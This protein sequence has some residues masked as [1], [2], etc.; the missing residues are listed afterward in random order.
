MPAARASTS[1]VPGSSWDAAVR[2]LREQPGQEDLVRAA[3]YDDPL[4]GAAQRYWESEEWQA[5][6]AAIGPRRGRAL[7]VG[8]G[9]GIASFALARDGFDVVALEPDSS[10]LVGS[11]AIRTLA[12]ETDLP[13]V[14]EERLSKSLPFPDAHFDLVFC[15][16]VLHH[17]PD[18]RE[19]MKEFA[20][21][22][23]VGGTFFAIR[24]H[25]VSRDADLPEFLDSHPLHHRYGGEHAYRAEVY[26]EA[27]ER[28]GLTIV[29]VFRSLDTP[30]NFAPRT[31]EEVNSAIVDR[32][33]PLPAARSIAR[34]AMIHPAIGRIVRALISR[35][36][37]RPG[38]HYSFL[39]RKER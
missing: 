18:L 11:E 10:P 33:I 3:Y 8:A 2:W 27:I 29:R 20:R 37:G 36:D 23:K 19:A 1:P 31:T 22:L 30:I 16:A 9:R 35:A 13:I 5:V 39:A 38:R 14:V 4:A 15:R 12:R 21:L 24:E 26:R 6:M 32:L 28:A 25:V 7:D 17:I 34:G